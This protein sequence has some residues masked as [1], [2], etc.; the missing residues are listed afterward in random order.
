MRASWTKLTDKVD[1]SFLTDNLAE[2]V[3]SDAPVRRGVSIFGWLVYSQSPIS[4]S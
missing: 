4:Y 1:S 2:S 3:V